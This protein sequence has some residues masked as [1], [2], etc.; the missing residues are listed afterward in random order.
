[1]QAYA[2][3]RPSLSKASADRPRLQT[4]CRPAGVHMSRSSLTG[5]NRMLLAENTSLTP[6]NRP[7][8][9]PYQRQER[10]IHSTDLLALPI[11]CLI[12][13]TDAH[14]AD[15]L[16][17]T[18][19]PWPVHSKLLSDPQGFRVPRSSCGRLPTL[20]A[21]QSCKPGPKTWNAFAFLT[22]VF[23]LAS[24]LPNV[25]GTVVQVQA[26]RQASCCGVSRPSKTTLLSQRWWPEVSALDRVLYY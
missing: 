18:K 21:K 17:A 22:S 13:D 6:D 5:V 15:S 25:G 14:I 1:M 19:K 24:R 16:R 11:R 26:G 12:G 7:L 10:K 2:C 8:T 23:G 20:P 3:I 9:P 4:N